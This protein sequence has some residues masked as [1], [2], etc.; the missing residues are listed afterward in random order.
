MYDVI[1][2]GGGPA[3]S[4]A[5]LYAKQYGLKTIVLDKSIF[6]RDKICGDALSGKCIRIM[7]ELD[8][9]EGLDILGGAAINSI[10]F[11]SPSYKYFNL[12]LKKSNQNRHYFRTSKNF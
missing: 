10:T 9:L 8:L 1:I 2:V 5:A 7:R 4:S 12:D 3:G 11:G 6:P